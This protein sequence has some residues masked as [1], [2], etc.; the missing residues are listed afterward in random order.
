MFLSAPFLFSALLLLLAL[1]ALGLF[2]CWRR[3]EAELGEARGRVI[4]L[5]TAAAKDQEAHTRERAQLE[6]QQRFLREQFEH[7]A[8]RIFEAQQQAFDVRTREGLGRLLAP[9]REQLEAFR[10]RVDQVHTESVRGQGELQGELQRLR[11]LNLQ[12]TREASELTR[13]LKGDKKLQGSWGEQ[14]V[15]LLLE[16]AGLRKGIEY[17]REASCRDEAGALLRPDFVVRLPEG[18]HLVIDSKVSLVDYAAAVAAETPEARGRALAAHVQALRAHIRT[19]GGKRYAQLPDLGAPDFTFLFVAV[20]PAYLAAAEQAP[21]LFEEA[22]QEG[23][24]LITASTL[25]PVLRVVAHLWSLQRQAQC[26]RELAEQGARVH[27]KL[28]VFLG[29]MDLLGR[30]LDTAQRT[31]RESLDTLRDGRGSLVRSVDRFVDL[32]VKVSRRLGGSS[33]AEAEPES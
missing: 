29:R 17:L 10:S 24:A 15:E 19:L 1:G 28:R 16:Q 25:L 3:A 7:L 18:R 32:G 9:F 5:E 26:T 8:H 4:A 13:A 31:Y 20:E 27:E 2:R 22:F 23:V 33:D 21:G 11:E 6:A 30:Q 14:K 12:I